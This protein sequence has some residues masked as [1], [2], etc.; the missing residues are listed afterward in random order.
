MKDHISDRYPVQEEEE[1]SHRPL[2]RIFTRV[3]GHYDLINR[4]FTLRMDERWR[5]RATRLLMENN[6]KKVMDLCTG[7]GD[8][9][10][11]V[12]CEADDQVEVTGY[13]FSR[14]MLDIA[15]RKSAS[16]GAG[17]IRFIQGDAAEMPFQNGY[18]DAVGIAFAFRNLT[19]KNPHTKEFIEEISRVLEKGGRFVIVESSQ[20]SNRVLRFLFRIY[21]RNMVYRLGSLISGNRGAYRYLA[22]SVINYYSP[23]EVEDLLLSHGFSEVSHKRLMGGVAAIHTAIK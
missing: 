20:P 14:P 9:A 16:A 10:I 18:F 22:N 4:L 23:K 11:H 13:D 7:T 21:T 17:K 15:V 12:A 5:K 19:Y 8:L 1:F 6:P 3:T 2:Y